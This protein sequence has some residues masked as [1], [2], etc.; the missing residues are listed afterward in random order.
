MKSPVFLHRFIARGDTDVP[1]D[2]LETGNSDREEEI[3]YPPRWHEASGFGT[4]DD[5]DVNGFGVLTSLQSKL[6]ELTGKPADTAPSPEL[7]TVISRG[8]R[9]WHDR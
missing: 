2:F 3:I 6:D 8:K 1:D 4:T 7:S 9:I 5:N